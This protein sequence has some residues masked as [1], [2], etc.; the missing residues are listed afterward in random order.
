MERQA[1]SRILDDRVAI[2][3]QWIQGCEPHTLNRFLMSH[4]KILHR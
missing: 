2:S 4:G 3:G 1:I